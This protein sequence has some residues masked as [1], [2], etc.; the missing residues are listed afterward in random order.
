MDLLHHINVFMDIADQGSLAAVARTRSL[1][2]SAVTATLQRLEEY[3]GIKLILRST[4]TLSLTPEGARFCEKC[5]KI[6]GDLD[7]AIDQLTDNGP[8][9]GAIRITSVNDFGRTHLSSFIDRFLEIHPMVRFDLSL[10][11]EVVDLITDGYDM[12]IRTGPLPDSQLSARAIVHGG[13]SV[14]ASPAYWTKYGKPEHPNDLAEHNCLVLSRSVNPQNVWLF[15][16]DG[17]P[18]PVHVTG[19]R[20]A[21]D[22]GLLRHWAV[23]GNGVVLKSDIDIRDDLKAG[24]LETALDEFKQEQ[25]NLYIVHASGQHLS[26]RVRAFVEYLVENCACL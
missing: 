13:R 21:N 10:G 7:E 15:Q 16:D 11:D 26:R 24:R 22:G 25:V 5:R 6:L 14:C 2:P 8:L 1:T 18:L 20:T 3:L 17:R 23:S 19:N 12:A 4:R 9:K